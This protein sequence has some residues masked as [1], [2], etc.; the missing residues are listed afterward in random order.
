MTM[1]Y[2]TLEQVLSWQPCHGRDLVRHALRSKPLGTAMDFHVF[3]DPT[4]GKVISG[5][6]RLWAGMRPEML[7]D[8]MGRF[9]ACRMVRMATG[10]N[11]RPWDHVSEAGRWLDAMAEQDALEEIVAAMGPGRPLWGDCAPDGPQADADAV[12]VMAAVGLWWDVPERLHD[13]LGPRGYDRETWDSLA[14]VATEALEEV[15]PGSDLVP[16]RRDG[17]WN[18]SM[19]DRALLELERAGWPSGPTAR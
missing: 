4:G 19:M 8:R 14:R 13:C 9:V 1:K 16:T 7:D 17:R 11:G 15:W 2:V 12:A 6:D 18:F 5:R 3:P 10:P